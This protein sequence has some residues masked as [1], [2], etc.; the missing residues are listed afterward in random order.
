M[1][2]WVVI[3]PYLKANICSGHF[4]KKIL[5]FEKGNFLG[6]IHGFGLLKNTFGFLKI[7]RLATLHC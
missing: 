2:I 5:T 6:F 3:W 4:L 1:L 7:L